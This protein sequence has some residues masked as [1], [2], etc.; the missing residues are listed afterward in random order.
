MTKAIVIRAHGGPEQLQIEDV[1]VGEPAP[2]ELRV[3]QA[4][5]GVNFHD[6]YVRSGLY[7][8]L[9]LPGVPGI[10]G[11][12][13]VEAVGPGVTDFAAGDRIGYVAASYGSYAEARLLPAALAVR[14]PDDM[15]EETAAAVFVK[16]LTA[17]FLV[18]RTHRILPGQTILV[19]AAAG[20]VGQLLCQWA[21]HLGATVIGTVGSSEKAV[22]ARKC[23]C[24]HTILSREEDFV[25]RAKEI[26]GG[27]GVDVAYDS[28][29][30]DTFAGSLAA[31]ALRGHLINFGQSSGP[32]DP[33]SVS[34]LS[35]RSNSLTRPILFHYIATRAELEALAGELFAALSGGILQVGE[36]RRFA[37]AEAADAH[38][39]LEARATSGSV[40]LL[41]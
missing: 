39:A 2:G 37:L 40:L 35:A 34:N 5:I 19:H 4:A 28:V 7:K 41:P 23:G 16:G 29:G 12:G 1:A 14:L 38:R 33:F 9:V 25:S 6:C 8:T 24:A 31:L 18:L 3:R 11:A 26:T 10:E 36:P 30:R 27:R 22:L 32:V 13:V 20:G 21:S 17:A 15:T